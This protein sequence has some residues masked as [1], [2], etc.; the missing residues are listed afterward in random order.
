MYGIATYCII[1]T[2]QQLI[3]KGLKKAHEM[4]KAEAKIIFVTVVYILIS[5]LLLVTLTHAVVT[6]ERE[7]QILSDY[8]QCQSTGLHPGK[9][10]DETSRHV[11]STPLDTL[12]EVAIILEGLIPICALIFV[13]KCNCNHKLFKKLLS[14]K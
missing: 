13:A 10:C 14:E 9:E 3:G 4:G 6:R 2:F 7:I 12:V 1:I 5:S 11:Q 8:F